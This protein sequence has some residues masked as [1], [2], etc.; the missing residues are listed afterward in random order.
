MCGISGIW[1][2]GQ[3]FSR[4]AFSNILKTAT[5]RMVNRGPDSSGYWT[6]T[7]S[8]IGF[9]FRRLAILDLS[10]NAN[11]PMASS[12]GRYH[13]VFN[14][15]VYNFLE[16]K[17]KLLA[18]NPNIPFK[19]T[20]DSEVVLNAFNHWGVSKTAAMLNGM[21]AIGLWDETKQELHL[22][23]D[24]IGKKPLYYGWIH[25]CFAFASELKVFRAIP[26]FNNS[27]S[28]DALSLFM[29]HNYVPTPYS[30]FEGIFKAQP[31]E[32]TTFNKDRLKSRKPAQEKYWS[33]QSV[34]ENAKNNPLESYDSRLHTLLRDCVAKR[35]VSDVPV[36]AFLSGGIDSSL[37][38][39]LMQEQSK[40]PV[41]TFTIGFSE[42]EFNEAVYAKDVAKHLK[43]DH[44]DLYFS[45]SDTLGVIPK[46]SSVYDEPFAD[47]SQIPTFLVSQLARKSV[48]V[49][50]SGD[51]GDELF[52]GYNRYFL[53]EALWNK[54]N[55]LPV[56]MRT[57]FSSMGE[58]VPISVLTS[59]YN[60]L[61]PGLPKKLVFSNPAD[62]IKK[63]LRLMKTKNID[64]LYLKMVSHVDDP[65]EIVL[66]SK[67]VT[68]AI[69]D[70]NLNIS[71]LSE[72]ES[73][74]YRDIMT[75]L[76]D[77][78]LVKV[79]R[80]SMANSLEARNP[81]LDYRMIEFSWQVPINQ[82]IKNGVGKLPLRN[83]L[84]QYIPRELIERPKMGF[85]VPIEKW[86]RGP[87]KDWCED[88]LSQKRI[89]EDGF[90]NPEPIQKMWT[91]HKS[92]KSNWHYQLWNVLIFNS[93]LQETFN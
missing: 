69:D 59:I 53:T 48:T 37:V 67:P 10:S 86:L 4:D 11:Q 87:L 81:L 58:K 73:M 33:L 24:R 1:D 15:E 84:Y 43:A 47:S 93:W 28:R 68:T 54:M 75:Y 57:L 22:I 63:I 14:G 56:G 26:G 12:N 78:I 2:F 29:R 31:G 77:D 38:V 42:D 16:I 83:L 52:G 30:I 27:I 89:R 70:P 85:G 72:I 6:S 32:I 91:E 39:A 3:T 17:D 40:T 44:T 19:S 45:P 7:H 88:L 13:M 90:F 36:G 46:I 80:A 64:Q 49:A 21:F 62:K 76:M 60:A 61:A 66:D 34:V 41:K 23:R 8:P 5:D 50:L 18:E 79:D 25:N 55:S 20:S 92:G 82:K 71:S 35:M 74:M 9:G 51:G 65:Y